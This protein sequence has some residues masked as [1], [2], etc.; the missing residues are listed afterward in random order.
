MTKNH[1]RNVC[2]GSCARTRV[3]PPPPQSTF[4]LQLKVGYDN[5]SSTGLPSDPTANGFLGF[6]A[7][8]FGD[9]SGEIIPLNPTTPNALG[10][11]DNDLGPDGNSI[12]FA[13][14]NTAPIGAGYAFYI[15]ATDPTGAGAIPPFQTITFT[16]PNTSGPGN[17]ITYSQSDSNFQVVSP[18]FVIWGPSNATTGNLAFWIAAEPDSNDDTTT[19]DIK[20]VR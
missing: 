7:N 5:D 10:Q 14:D 6:C 19:L 15:T 1:P 13:Y 8:G 2:L 16:N 11:Y 12:C 18:G 3:P 9:P 17:S 4:F 20:L